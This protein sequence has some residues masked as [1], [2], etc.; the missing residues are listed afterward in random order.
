[1]S[2][3]SIG[4]HGIFTMDEFY[5]RGVIKLAPDV[6]VYI[7]GQLEPT[8]IA[9]V[10]SS[11]S[12]H[13]SFNDGITNVSIQ[14]NIETP[15]QSTATIEVVTPIYGP[16]SNYWTT[17]KTAHGEFARA[18]VFVPMLEV[19]IYL[20][21]RFMVD[22]KPRYYPAF[23][24]FITQVD[25][26]Y[27]GGLYKF[28]L[29]C[30]DMLHW[31]TYSTLNIHPV[32][33]S[34][35][36]SRGA[37]KLTVYATIFDRGNPYNI[38]YALNSSMGMHEFVTPTW[39]AQKTAMNEIYP[40]DLFKKVSSGI[41]E[42][43]NLRLRNT[44]NLLKMYGIDGLL[45]TEDGIKKKKPDKPPVRDTSGKSN[46][47]KAGKPLDVNRHSPDIPF[48]NSF[49]V[50][51]DY[52]KMGAF[53]N[54]EY[55]TK[56]E[57][58]TEVKNRCNFEFFQDTNGN[59]VFK[60]PFYNMNVKGLMP[61]TVLPSDII[62]YSVNTDSEGIITVMNI[63]T[64]MYKNLRTT[65]WD[66]GQGFH[67]DI[68]LAKRYGIRYKSTMLEYVTDSRMARTLALGQMSQVNAKT[69]TGSVTM[70]GRPE[71]RLG[72]PIYMEHRDSF[73]YVKSVNHSFDYGGSFTTTLAL[74][75]ERQQ[76]V[77]EDKLYATLG[78]NRDLI[79]KLKT[80]P[81]SNDEEKTKKDA[82]VKANK[83][84]TNSNKAP[85]I[86]ANTPDEEMQFLLSKKQVVGGEDGEYK[87]VKRDS[88]EPLRTQQMTTTMT[89][90]PL[91]D[92]DGYK[93]IGSFPYGRNINPVVI[94]EELT[95]PPVFK[96]VFLSTMARPVYKSESEAMSV[97]FFPDK[98]GAVPSYLEFVQ[99][100]GK[101]LPLT[102]GTI[103]D[104]PI[105]D[106]ETKTPD[107]KSMPKVKEE[108]VKKL[109]N[110]ESSVG[111]KTPPDETVL[112]AD[113]MKKNLRTASWDR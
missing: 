15:G 43:W 47:K 57:I 52:D 6:L 72:Y 45:V 60:P 110:M 58:A 32:P 88:E 95:S 36:Y 41:M 112:V 92:N 33:E 77:V 28:T 100:T 74:E 27:N 69:L 44:A 26:S 89:S 51:A 42:Y 98:E 38:L 40:A 101:D 82:A 87:V 75:T 23:W 78:T 24:G 54:A 65:A 64:P 108:D 67:M 55:M 107:Q 66:L 94:A 48:L 39:V 7:G 25:E 34:N 2:G 83:D 18:P 109:T 46:I 35:V 9:P 73:H 16:K 104:V 102:L 85:K 84:K 1:M 71:I 68:E 59:F 96:D 97:L 11:N 21:G 31:W 91:S 13:M 19:K 63:T 17:Y 106:P 50:F 61:Y 5:N 14:N 37:Q 29:N 70:P 22:M 12:S 111:N 20:K 90:I 3:P 4:N 103:K 79:Y 56:L 49:E 76:T 62:S 10:T 8:V 93:L 99:R 80:D 30:A 86:D 53:E 81:K 105:E 113:T